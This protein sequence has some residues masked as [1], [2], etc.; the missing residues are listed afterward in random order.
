[1]GTRTPT[2]TSSRE[3]R[4]ILEDEFRSAWDRRSGHVQS[5]SLTPT[6]IRRL[7]KNGAVTIDQDV[8][9]HHHHAHR[10][11]GGF[12]DSPTY[13]D[14][15]IWQVNSAGYIPG[16][17][18]PRVGK[19][20]IP[21]HAGILIYSHARKGSLSRRLDVE[22][23]EAAVVGRIVVIRFRIRAAEHD[24]HSGAAGRA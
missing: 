18:I 11:V 12:V 17:C 3:L 21:G 1:M 4:S 20:D 10:S 5:S 7:R 14:V 19:V 24:S 13:G 22:R 23:A 15:S 9:C 8:F 2:R 6:A 16:R